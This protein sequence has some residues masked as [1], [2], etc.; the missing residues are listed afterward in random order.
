MV[1]TGASEAV[2]KV[3]TQM[4]TTLRCAKHV[5]HFSNLEQDI[6]QYHLHDALDNF[7]ASLVEIWFS[8]IST[9][10]RRR[11]GETKGTLVSCEER[12]ILNLRIS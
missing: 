11:S 3:P 9:R 5:L 6:G 12:K 2:E 4:A 8:S 10:G 1:K 7:P